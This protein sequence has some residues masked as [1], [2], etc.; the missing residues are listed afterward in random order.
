MAF[1]CAVAAAL[2]T[3]SGNQKTKEAFITAYGDNLSVAGLCNAG[4]LTDNVACTTST[5]AYGTCTVTFLNGSTDTAHTSGC[6]LTYYRTL[7]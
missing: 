4:T 7:P 1:L 5:T 3:T 6:A 2:A